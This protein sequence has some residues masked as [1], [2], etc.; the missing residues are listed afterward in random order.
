MYEKEST[1]PLTRYGIVQNEGYRASDKHGSG[2]EHVQ[3]LIYANYS[4][5]LWKKTGA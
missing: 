2:E 5:K 4:C 1:K 3:H